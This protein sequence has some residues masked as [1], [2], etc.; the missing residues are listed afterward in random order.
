MRTRL[1]VMAT[2]VG[3]LLA[4]FSV[5]TW[6]Q[7]GSPSEPAATVILKAAR[8]F[9]GVTM[10]DGWAVRVKGDRIEAAGKLP[11]AAKTAKPAPK[12]LVP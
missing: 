12:G 1:L 7:P 11:E 5:R 10:H 9:D 2:G 3:L 8:V 6:A 4:A